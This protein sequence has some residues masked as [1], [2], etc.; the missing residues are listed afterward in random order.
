MR[1]DRKVE[2][3]WFVCVRGRKE[4]VSDERLLR[5]ASDARFSSSAAREITEMPPRYF[6]SLSV[7]TF[8]FGVL[9]QLL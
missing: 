9:A 5:N 6:H 7:T 2:E 1:S 8:A 3:P 4:C